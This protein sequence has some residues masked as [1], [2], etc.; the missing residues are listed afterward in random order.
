MNDLKKLHY[1]LLENFPEDYSNFDEAN[2]IEK[3]IDVL[4]YYISTAEELESVIADKSE[5]EDELKNTKEK[6]QD[7]KNVVNVVDGFTPDITK[8]IA[9]LLNFN[10]KILAVIKSI[11]LD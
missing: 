4:R 5:I 9:L 6:L 8:A 7:L 3:T 1:F 2:I 11:D 10:E